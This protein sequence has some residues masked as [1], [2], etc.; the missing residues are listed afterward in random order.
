MTVGVHHEICLE[1][2]QN[3]LPM[4]KTRGDGLVYQPT[5]IDKRTGE[6]K[7]ASTW[8]VQYFVKGARFRESTNSRSRPEAEDF[9]QQRLKAGAQGT[10]VGPK[11]GKAT[12]E[13]LAKILL[14]DYRAKG[15]RSLGRVEDAVGHLR[16]FF[17][18]THAGEI[19]GD[20]IGRYVSSRQQEGAAAATIN[21]EL[22]ALRRAFRL[23]QSAG[24]VAF[25]PEILMLPEDNRREDFFEAAE[26]QTVLDNL[27]EYLRPVIQTAYITGWRINSEILTREKR[28]VDLDSGCL[29][30]ESDGANDE[31]G[32]SFPLATELRKVLLRQLEK[33]AEIEQNTGRI[34][35]WLFHREGKPIKDFRKAWTAACQRAGVVGKVPDD[36]RRT[37]VRNLERAGVSRFAA[38]M[39]VGHRSE[40][41]Y[42]SIALI[43]EVV[44][45]ES[46]AKLT[47]FHRLERNN[48]ARRVRSP[49][50]RNP[51]DKE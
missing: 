45:D 25:R 44:L 6:R 14:D 47:A 12:F 26:Y 17:A 2:A 21:R 3:K 15:R 34:I 23:A 51:H 8:W 31:K 18:T 30:F 28:H 37:A 49:A 20:L 13:D 10:P 35:P 32:R 33:T 5:Y 29:R 41:I 24:K 19:S 1:S 46:A 38:M 39:M 7:T 22:G 4:K 36:F 11:A 9:L 50:E 43:D 27:P 42:H 40:S 16:R 48:E